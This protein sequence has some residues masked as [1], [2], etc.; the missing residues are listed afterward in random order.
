M[1]YFVCSLHYQTSAVY[2]ERT[3][4]SERFRTV[5][6]LAR[7]RS[8]IE[9]HHRMLNLRG[10]S[11][12]DGAWL[13]STFC[14]NAKLTE[15][16]L[17]PSPKKLP[18]SPSTAGAAH[19][20]LRDLPRKAGSVSSWCIHRIESTLR[21]YNAYVLSLLLRFNTCHPHLKRQ[22]RPKTF[23]RS[24][25]L[26]NGQYIVLHCR[27]QAFGEDCPFLLLS[28]IGSQDVMSASDRKVE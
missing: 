12:D 26:L 17:P 24:P 15:M 21:K 11:Q 28:G 22:E 3:P 18:Y 14:R 10:A 16:L 23:S 25:V 1:V 4:S 6:D 13:T 20:I 2:G 9:F 5:E 19:L 7:R 27:F 8:T